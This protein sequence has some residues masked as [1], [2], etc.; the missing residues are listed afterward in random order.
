MAKPVTQNC[1]STCTYND[2]RA[3]NHDKCYNYKAVIK[4]QN[5]I[6]VL[7]LWLH[8]CKDK[9][10]NTFFTGACFHEKKNYPITYN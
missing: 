1:A 9:K 4:C 2:F 10:L 3:N 5:N 8:S 7:P 6:K